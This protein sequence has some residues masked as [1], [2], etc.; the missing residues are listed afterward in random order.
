MQAMRKA[1]HHQIGEDVLG[2]KR[3]GV[4]VFYAAYGVAGVLAAGIRLARRLGTSSRMRLT[5]KA[6][7]PNEDVELSEP[8]ESGSA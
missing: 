8:P 6:L 4:F 3:A 7:P 5:H 2:H 1:V